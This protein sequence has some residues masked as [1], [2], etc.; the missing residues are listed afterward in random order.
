MVKYFMYHNISDRD[1]KNEMY[2]KHY[3]CDVP[4]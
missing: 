1:E 3:L 2:D 4:M